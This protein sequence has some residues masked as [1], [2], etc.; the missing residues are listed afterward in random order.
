MEGEGKERDRPEKSHT[1]P[2][3]SLVENKRKIFTEG[4]KENSK[5]RRGEKEREKRKKERRKRK[6]KNLDSISFGFRGRVK[7]KSMAR[8][9]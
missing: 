6:I 7:K 4:L 3:G 5:K 8:C 9:A 1:T 2:I